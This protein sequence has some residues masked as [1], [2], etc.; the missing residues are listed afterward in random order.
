MDRRSLVLRSLMV[1]ACGLGT[2][3]VLG[4]HRQNDPLKNQTLIE[5]TR[6]GI[7]DDTIVKLIETD[8][9]DFDTSP[10]ALVALKN[11]GVSDRVIEAILSIR[12]QKPGVSGLYPQPDEIGVYANVR[13]RLVQLRVEI[14]SWR[15]GGVLKKSLLSRGHLNGQV[16]K[17][18]SPIRLDS[19]PEF[20]VYCPEGV[21][22]EEYQLL[23]FW[24]KRDRREFRITTGGIFHASSGA[25]MNDLTF[26]VMKLGTRLYLVTPSVPLA[27]G[28]YGFLPPGAVASASA[29]S[30]GKMYT[31]GVMEAR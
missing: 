18:V 30:A 22:A 24:E 25:D 3:T 13:E 1:L 31:F 20:I 14:I 29:A 23:R 8:K 28:E 19:S 21:V 4:A 26:D 11:A 5:M 2:V 6:A 10:A 17:P 15:T 9:G 7:S 27:K 16:M 12:R